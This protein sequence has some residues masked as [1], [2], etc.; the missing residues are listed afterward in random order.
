MGIDKKKKNVRRE[1]CSPAKRRG[2]RQT[3]KTESL[4]A[5]TSQTQWKRPTAPR[6]AP[7]ATCILS[8]PRD[9]RLWSTENAPGNLN[10]VR[11]LIVATSRQ[12]SPRHTLLRP[13]GA[14]LLTEAVWALVGELIVEEAE[15]ESRTTWL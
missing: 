3:R 5:V 9:Y 14:E 2:K 11:H 8:P 6:L 4:E 1:V 15:S 7:D 12:E 13:R 10:I